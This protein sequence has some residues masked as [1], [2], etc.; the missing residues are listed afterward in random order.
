MICEQEDS[1]NDDYNETQT[2]NRMNIFNSKNLNILLVIIFIAIIVVIYMMMKT[3]SDKTKEKQE[4]IF[5]LIGSDV[6]LVSPISTLN[7]IKSCSLFF[8]STS[9]ILY[10]L[11]SC[12]FISSYPM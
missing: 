2:S 6:I 1:M 3:P 4:V 10:N 12:N 7:M 11:P 9:L 5:E 8:D